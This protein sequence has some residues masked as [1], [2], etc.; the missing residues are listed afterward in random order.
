MLSAKKTKDKV[1][2][3][4]LSSSDFHVFE[5]KL[6][7][8][9]MKKSEFFR[10]VFINSNVNLTVKAAPSKDHSALLFLYNKSS[11]NLNQLAH[12][13]N[14]AHLSGAVNRAQYLK[15]INTLIEIRE[16]MLAGISHVN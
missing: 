6:A 1:V 3:F 10:E 8:S 4:R 15:Y 7:S 13:V 14:I 16:L 11:N 5:T 9:N 2:A 12:Q